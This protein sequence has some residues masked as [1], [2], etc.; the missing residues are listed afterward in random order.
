MNEITTS[1]GA[2]PETLAGDTDAGFINL[3]LK[4]QRSAHT[5]RS[6]AKDLGEF[7]AFTGGRPL[8]DVQMSEVQCFAESLGR[9][10]VEGYQSNDGRAA[11]THARILSTLKSL[12]SFAHRTGYLPY[13]VGQ[14]IAVPRIPE[15]LA[16]RILTEAEMLRMIHGEN[17]PRNRAVLLLLYATGARVSEAARLEWRHLKAAESGAHVTLFGKG[18]KTRTVRIPGTVYEALCALRNDTREDAPVFRSNKGGKLT[19][20]AFWRIVRAAA[21]RAGITGDVSPHW[22]RHCTASHALD[23][24]CSLAVIKDTLG[25]ASLTTSSRYIHAKPTDSA[26]LHL[27]L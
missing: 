20:S 14:A 23:R 15:T 24:G 27:P 7:L 3:W 11:S 5:R 17:T 21:K 22:I 18:G 2:L 12:L 8:C 25:H 16:E 10:S 13:N 19:P 6:Y 26:G 4:R 1:A 9:E